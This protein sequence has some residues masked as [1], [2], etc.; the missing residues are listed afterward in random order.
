MQL[1]IGYLGQVG[2][3]RGKF[4]IYR[5]SRRKL[6]SQSIPRNKGKTV[7]FRSIIQGEHDSNSRVHW[8]ASPGTHHKILIITQ[9]SISIIIEYS[10]AYQ[11]LVLFVTPCILYPAYIEH[12]SV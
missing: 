2:M 3:K 6:V 7:S 5:R 8:L 9:A 4:I 11:H 10:Y 12:S 1:S